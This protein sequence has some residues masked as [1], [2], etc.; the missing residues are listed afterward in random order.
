MPFA[1]I[2][3]AI[4]GA[5][6]AIGSSIIGSKAQKDAQ[7][8]AEQSPLALAQTD[9]AKQQT[10]N[11]G[12]ASDVSKRLFPQYESGI[13]DLTKYYKALTGPSNEPALQAIAPLVQA[14]KLQTQA[15]LRNA[16]LLPRGGAR[17]SEYGRIYDNEN[18]DILNTLAGAR[19]NA[20]N[21]YGA[22]TGN[23]G[24]TASNLLNTSGSLNNSA[25]GIYGLVQNQ[26][27]QAQ[28]QA[29]QNTGN[30]LGSLGESFGPLLIE[31]MKG[32]GSSGGG[33]ATAPN[34]SFGSAGKVTP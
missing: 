32:G 19:N 15:S 18:T 26:S 22:L 10:A 33:D 29:A 2:L 7:K 5:G 21:S 1:A 14:R 3:P 27:L 9:L 20:W 6:G 24:S 17:G 16:D 25:A 31:L 8:R 28:N 23:I 12:Y 13:A 11:A 34:P 4:I 30:L